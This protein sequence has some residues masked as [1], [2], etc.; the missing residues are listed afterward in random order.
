MRKMNTRLPLAAAAASLLLPL[1]GQAAPPP[2]VASQVTAAPTR[3]KAGKPVML[4]ASLTNKSATLPAGN[5]DLEVY[6]ARNKKVA[7]HTWSGQVLAKNK[8]QAYH[9]AWKPAAVGTY[10][11]KVG[12]FSSDWKTLC[13]WADK[14]LI[15]PV[16]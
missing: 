6:D 12:V 13:Y 8:P 10:T 7:Q 16:S 3:A 5:V 4:S 1:V 2:A 9:W 11:I 15:V 14:A